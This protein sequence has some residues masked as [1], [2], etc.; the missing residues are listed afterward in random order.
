MS[1][2]LNRSGR[3]LV[4]TLC[5]ALMVGCAGTASGTRSSIMKAPASS[6]KVAAAPVAL[7]T[8]TDS[9]AGAL[10][11]IRYPAVIRSDA[12]STFFQ[13]FTTNAIDGVVESA[14]HGSPEI[15]RTA[16]AMVAKSGYYAMSLYRELKATMPAGSV[17][18][19]PHAIVLDSQGRLSSAPILATE[20]VP[21]VITFDFTAYTF[22]DPDKMMDKPPLTFGDVVT[23]MVVVSTDPLASP[24]THGLLVSSSPILANAWQQSASDAGATASAAITGAGAEE[25]VARPLALIRFLRDGPPANAKYPTKQVGATP[26]VAAVVSYPVEKIKVDGDKLG[27]IKEDPSIDPLADS[28]ARGAAAQVSR[29]LGSVDHDYAL[30][31]PMQRALAALDL[32]VAAA[33]LSAL[34][35]ETIRARVRLADELLAA[36]RQFFVRQSEAIYDGVY[37]GV[38]GGKMREMITEEYKVLQERRSLARQQ[39]F[40]MAMSILAAAA[41]GYTQGQA[42]AMSAYDPVAAQNMMNASSQFLISS[43]Q[44]STIASEAEVQSTVLG[45][46]FLTAMAPTINDQV[47]LQV[48]LLGGSEEIRASKYEE[49]QPKLVDLYRK[50]A[51]SIDANV[52]AECTFSHPSAA[53]AGRWYGLCVNGQAS[54]RGFGIALDA[55]A[56]SI[57]YIGMAGEGLAN[58]PGYLMLRPAAGAAGSPVAY[59]GTFSAGLPDGVVRVRAAGKKPAFRSF[60]AGKDVGSG[61]AKNFVE[62]PI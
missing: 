50:N 20:I 4:V 12:E 19:S 28:F 34:D 14:K 1:A 32:E 25:P 2:V 31:A 7:K 51:R 42:S 53:R 18:L 26:D 47:S 33:Y 43:M 52:S 44:F 48:D 11:I 39:N 57:E 46:N 38:F 17:L 16:R 23:P 40:S 55:A 37:A 27:M 62:P 45:E 15:E 8:A 29:L 58:G 61:D 13:S 49:L 30:L 21:S 3:A 5:V 6:S 24:S 22:P 35:N 60:A 36:Q 10:V 54:G 9:K 59:E 41:S 56:G